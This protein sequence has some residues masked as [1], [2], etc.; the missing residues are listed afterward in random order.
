MQNSNTLQNLIAE[1]SDFQFDVYR[2]FLTRR[3]ILGSTSQHATRR[4]IKKDNPGV[5]FTN[6]F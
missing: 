4:E 1:K 2:R 5:P 3:C 6:M